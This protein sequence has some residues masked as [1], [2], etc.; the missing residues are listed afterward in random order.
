MYEC[1]RSMMKDTRCTYIQ[2][3]A[4]TQ[5]IIQSRNRANTHTCHYKN[6]IIASSW[7]NTVMYVH[8]MSKEGDDETAV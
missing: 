2:N 4:H 5:T 8:D 3:N 6:I 7:H 1:M